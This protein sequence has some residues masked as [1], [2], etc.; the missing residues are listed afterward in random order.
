MTEHDFEVMRE[1]V[2]VYLSHMRS[3][4]DDV[5]E[6]ELRIRSI[7][8]RL[9]IMGVAY[10]KISVSTSTSGDTIGEGI[11][12]LEDLAGEL[13]DRVTTYERLFQE[14]Q[15][16]CQPRYVGRY[17]M[18]LHEVE[19]RE[20]AYVGRIIGYEERQARRI[21]DGGVRE[22]YELMPREY[23]SQAIPAAMI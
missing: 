16:I 1:C 12:T 11:A 22:I 21:A 15:D 7:R 10:D 23:Q 4:W 3:Y 9:D 20:W 2:K 17:A 8:N 6:I 18:W 13:E 5:R 14:A 19:G